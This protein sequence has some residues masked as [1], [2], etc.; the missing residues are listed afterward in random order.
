MSK[1]ESSRIGT[2]TNKLYIFLKIDC[3][4]YIELFNAKSYVFFVTERSIAC[5][6]YSLKLALYE[7]TKQTEILTLN[8]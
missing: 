2:L 3:K 4:I 5:V 7:I 1:S 8:N 6:S